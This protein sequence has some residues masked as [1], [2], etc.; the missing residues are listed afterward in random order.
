MRATKATDYREV[1]RLAQYAESEVMI[2]EVAASFLREFPRDPIVTVH[3][4]IIAP[5]ERMEWLGASFARGWRP[6]GR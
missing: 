3:D 6:I 2:D 5:K 4:E 1:A